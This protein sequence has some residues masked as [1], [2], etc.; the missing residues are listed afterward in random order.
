[1]KGFLKIS[2]ILLI[3]IGVIILAVCAFTQNLNDNL[4]L[5]TAAVLI[6]GGF[7]GYIVINKQIAD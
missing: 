2:G 7:I 1:M 3:L 6:L 4:Y 5:G